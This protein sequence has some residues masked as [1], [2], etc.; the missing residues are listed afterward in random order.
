MV[1]AHEAVLGWEQGSPGRARKLLEAWFGSSLGP[2]QLDTAKLLVSELVTNALVH[3]EG[4]ITFRSGL[5]DDEL[6]VEVIDEGAGFEVPV[7]RRRL[8]GSGGWGLQLVASEASRWGVVGGTTHV[9]FALER[10]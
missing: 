10:T 1:E 3:G 4:E 2:T 9:W 5:D 6:F 7:A 8:G